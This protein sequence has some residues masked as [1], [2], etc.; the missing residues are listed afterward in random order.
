[1][2]DQGEEELDPWRWF[3]EKEFFAEVQETTNSTLG[4]V[5]QSENG[6]ST[7]HEDPAVGVS[8]ERKRKLDAIEPQQEAENAGLTSQT[9]EEAATIDHT[10]LEE[11]SHGHENNSEKVAEEDVDDAAEQEKDEPAGLPSGKGLYA[12]YEC[13]AVL[14]NAQFSNRQKKKKAKRRR[15]CKRCMQAAVGR[16]SAAAAALPL[17]AAVL[18]KNNKDRFIE[19]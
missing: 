15:K 14:P 8:G 4:P 12:C 3:F 16:K 7:S 2:A 1:M 11:T 10:K 17:S 9:D 18:Y 13:G 5:L 6:A 19:A